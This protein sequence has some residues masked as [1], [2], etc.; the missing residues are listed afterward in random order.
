MT[1]QELLQASEG[2]P[3]KRASAFCFSLS[4]DE[5]RMLKETARRTRYS[6]AAILRAG[7]KLAAAQLGVS[8]DPSSGRQPAKRKRGADVGE[9]GSAPTP[10]SGE[11]RGVGFDRADGGS[12]GE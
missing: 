9:R 6:K 8:P 7:L 1:V 4:D 12:V 11:E 10:P 2:G 5:R 3:V